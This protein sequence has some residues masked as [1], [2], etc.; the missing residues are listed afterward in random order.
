MSDKTKMAGSSSFAT[1]ST[2]REGV[3]DRANLDDG[4]QGALNVEI[5]DEGICYSSLFFYS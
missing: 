2:D 5:R 3:D 1:V 4:H